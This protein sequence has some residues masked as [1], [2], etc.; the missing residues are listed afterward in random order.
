MWFQ[1]FM[2]PNIYVCLVILWGEVS[3]DLGFFRG[4]HRVWKSGKGMESQ[5]LEKVG[6]CP[7][8][9]WSSKGGEAGVCGSCLSTL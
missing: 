7:R 3:I 9:L 2:M 4:S 1:L 5:G 8:N 6:I